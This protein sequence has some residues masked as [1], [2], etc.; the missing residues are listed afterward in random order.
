MEFSHISVLYYET[1]DAL[2]IKPDGIYVDCTCGGAGH[3]RGV[4][5]RLG[6]NGRLIAI[7]QDP[8]AIEVIKERI[9]N[10]KR[11][12]IVHDN[13]SNLK[14]ILSLLGVGHVDGIMADLGVSSHQLDTA[15]RGFS[16]HS[17]APL[18]MRMSKQGMSAYDVVNTYDERD[19]ARILRD[20]G[21]EKFAS[22][23]A[24]S[25]VQH[26]Q[27]N[28]IE[29]TLELSDII[30]DAIPAA[31]RRTGGHPAKRSFQAI[32]IEVNGELSKLQDTLDDMFYS[33][34]E[35]GRLAIIT[36]HSLED[37]IV[38]KAFQNYCKGC[39]CPPQTPVCICG[40]TPEGKLSF[41]KKTASQQELEENMRSRSA[42]L[43]SV[44]R[45]K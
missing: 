5:E 33:L 34:N 8:E 44:E 28:P 25:I 12:T 11:V 2:D 36:F 22:R 24:R 9:G 14:Q 19:I 43:R 27:I 31:T 3:S 29:T 16:F 18:D 4:L 13:F 41:K 15:E 38:K 45:I 42:T 35:N 6:E 37:R 23:I 20:Y 26:R 40:K 21:E 7:D 1:L 17:D 39:E 10:D 30:K 32:R